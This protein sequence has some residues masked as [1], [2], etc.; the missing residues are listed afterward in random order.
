[1]LYALV[2]RVK[3]RTQSNRA[4]RSTSETRPTSKARGGAE[5][6]RVKPFDVQPSSR[7]HSP[8]VGAPIAEPQISLSTF[9][10]EKH[11][12]AV[13]K[14]G[15][16]LAALRQRLLQD[17]LTLSETDMLCAF[18]HKMEEAWGPIAFAEMW[19]ELSALHWCAAHHGDVGQMQALEENEALARRAST[20]GDLVYHLRN[21]I[22]SNAEELENLSAHQLYAAGFRVEDLFTR[23]D[24]RQ[25]DSEIPPW[26]AVDIVRWL[27]GPHRNI[28]TPVELS[29]VL[30]QFPDIDYQ[31]KYTPPGKG[32]CATVNPD[33]CAPLK[34]V[35]LYAVLYATAG[36]RS[37]TGYDHYYLKF[38]PLH[39]KAIIIDY[40]FNQFVNPVDDNALVHG[41]QV[42]FEDDVGR[43]I[44]RHGGRIGD[45]HFFD[46]QPRSEATALVSQ[47]SI[48]RI[49]E[50]L[51]QPLPAHH[52]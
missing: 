44:K 9:S 14:T 43:E 41:P 10:A 35:G 30:A 15:V 31:R 1:M 28:A 29:R 42:V 3:I 24:P 12:A 37:G 47:V 8:Q 33:A 45:A 50:K 26:E 25:N 36:P 22:L 27:S 20:T 18:L 5:A 13:A 2:I 39:G 17:K 32:E 6:K 51:K 19:T 38:F 16:T 21:E 46:G 4:N 34:A 52:P 40:S 48:R 49:D 23:H 7:A 11:T